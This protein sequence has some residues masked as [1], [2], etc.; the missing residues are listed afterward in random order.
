MRV[1]VLQNACS[2][3]ASRRRRAKAF[4][5]TLKNRGMA[6]DVETPPSAAHLRARAESVRRSSHDVLI[7]SGGD[8]TLS[9]AVNGLVRTPK[10]ERPALAVLPLGRGNDFAAEIGV[11]DE[12]DAL[13]ALAGSERRTV[14]LGRS[15]AGVF[16]GVAGTGFDARAA[17]RAQETPIL[18]GSLLY[19]YAVLRTLVDYRPLLARVR[20][21]GGEFEGPLMFAAAG[22]A[23]RYGGGMRIT[24]EAELD[25]GL[26][27]LCLVRE[28]SRATLLWMFPTVFSG[29]HLAHPR[30]EYHKT[31]FVEIETDE[32]A[33]VFADGEL[34]Q[35]TPIRMDVLPREIELVVPPVT[36]ASM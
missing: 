30:V 3:T 18:S 35:A 11:R 6:V 32:P 4:V 24:P 10:D 28:I 9:A 1:L 27:D 2:G 5:D 14:D 22:N 31:R 23:S 29:R 34:L 16:L 20:Y 21:E 26:L 12:G 25:D 13:R 36:V 19:T 15:G 7:V 8:G 33:E 17:R